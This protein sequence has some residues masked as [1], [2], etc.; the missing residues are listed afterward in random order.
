MGGRQGIFPP[1]R[2]GLRGVL[3][4]KGGRGGLCC[5]AVDRW[6]DAD[7]MELFAAKKIG[8]LKANKSQNANSNFWGRCSMPHDLMYF[9]ASILWHKTRKRAESTCFLAALKGESK[10]NSAGTFHNRINHSAAEA[11][12]ADDRVYLFAVTRKSRLKFSVHAFSKDGFSI[13]GEPFF[14]KRSQ[15]AGFDFPG[16]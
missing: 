10:F 1:T 11:G 9:Q 2:L 13:F 12:L 14:C 6:F 7:R 8:M 16:D 4:V 5:G 15:T 3:C